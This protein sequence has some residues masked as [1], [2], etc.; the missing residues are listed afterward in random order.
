MVALILS[1]FYLLARAQDYDA[2]LF[3]YILE[4]SVVGGSFDYT[5]GGANWEGICS[6]G[7]HQSPIHIEDVQTPIEAFPPLLID[8]QPLKG[9]KKGLTPG[10]LTFEVGEIV[11][12]M[13][14]VTVDGDGPFVYASEQIHF[15]SPSEHTLEGEHFDL[16]MQI[17]HKLGV[18]ES[19]GHNQAV[20]SVLF[21]VGEPNL[22]LDSIVQE[23][24]TVDLDLL[25][26]T[27][28][29]EDY[30]TYW[31]SLTTPP[32]TEKVN[33]YVW[34]Q[35]QEAS[36][37]QIAF[38]QNFWEKNE[39]FAS[40]NGNNRN[41]QPNYDRPILYRGS[42]SQGILMIAALLLVLI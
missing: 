14:A 21:K 28:T 41:I 18:N 24:F 1:V 27:D 11:G 19:Y 8:Y 38:F 12:D 16:E 5:L 31:G 17:K 20:L 23:K 26:E 9:P 6:S 4:Q 3:D 15:H 25:F 22:F 29:I 13:T 35:V 33:W 30:Y 40:G 37:E 36:E 10:L 32:C 39:A 42:I 34:N 2:G 7:K